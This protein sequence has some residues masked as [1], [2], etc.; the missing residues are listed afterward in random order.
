MSHIFF[1]IYI[2]RIIFK[3]KIRSSLNLDPSQIRVLLMR[4]WAPRLT[5]NQLR[6]QL[7]KLPPHRSVPFFF[8]GASFFWYF[9]L[10]IQNTTTRNRKIIILPRIS[11]QRISM[12][13]RRCRRCVSGKWLVGPSST[14]NRATSFLFHL[15]IQDA[16]TEFHCSGQMHRTRD[17]RAAG[18]H[19]LVSRVATHH[20]TEQSTLARC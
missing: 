17:A 16:A 13:V 19:S 2:F 15:A 3:F 1:L 8:S 18:C 14:S 7:G 11:V 10:T 4:F 6:R 20:V 5:L 9:W 12:S